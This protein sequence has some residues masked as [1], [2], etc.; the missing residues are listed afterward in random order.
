MGLL[1]TLFNRSPEKYE[2]KGDALFEA[3]AWGRAKIEYE[4]ALD[5][6][7]NQYPGH[8]REATRVRKK[9]DDTKEALASEHR[10]TA[11]GLM[12]AG[13][14]DEARDLLKLAIELS[15][16]Q[17]FT[18]EVKDLLIELEKQVGED[19]TL[20]VPDPALTSRVGEETEFHESEDETFIALLG[21]LPKDVQE[22]YMSYGSAF[23]SGYLAL[24]HGD[25]DRAVK[26]LTQA[27]DE[28]D[29]PDSYIPLE[30]ATAYLNL[31]EL[32]KACPLLE[33]FIQHHMDALPG[34]QVFC[35]VLWEMKAFDQAEAL[36]DNCPDELKDSSEHHLLRGETLFQAGQYSEAAALY[37]DFMENYGWNEYIAKARART[38]EALG[39]PEKAMTLYGEIINQ[40]TSCQSRVDPFVKRRFADISFDLGQRSSAILDLYFSLVQ[41]DP[42]NTPFYYQR[43]SEI[44]AS[45]GHEQEA[46]RFQEYSRRAEEQLL[47]PKAEG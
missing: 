12:E 37:E 39:D 31:G 16:D 45:Q 14:N 22:A 9:I 19:I 2:K 10:K 43:V 23:K 26:D 32:E 35:E 13:Y 8:S 47:R 7:E 30:L 3:A 25:F 11:E 42:M 15:Q 36:L 18:S 34:Y 27:M 5:A 21:A 24:N 33:T 40:C 29:A 41:E 1:K 28:N 44:Y 20:D 6:F 4:K 38:K 46:R 17:A